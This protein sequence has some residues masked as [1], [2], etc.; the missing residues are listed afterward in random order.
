MEN[1]FES[2]YNNFFEAKKIYEPLWAPRWKLVIIRDIYQTKQPIP[3]IVVKAETARDAWKYFETERIKDYPGIAALY[4]YN[5]GEF[6]FKFVPTDDL[7]HLET[8]RNK[9]I[10]EN[11]PRLPYRDD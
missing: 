11:P 5:K 9:E 6:A 7:D 4:K 8:K 1:K 2:L 10:E 3:T